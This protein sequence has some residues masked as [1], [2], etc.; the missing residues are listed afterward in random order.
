M[1]IRFLRRFRVIRTSRKI[2]SASLLVNRSSKNSTR[3]PVASRSHPPKD[4][5]GAGQVRVVW[6]DLVE[7]ALHRA[8]R[9]R[10]GVL[11]PVDRARR[12]W[13]RLAQA[14]DVIA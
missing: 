8:V 13:H 10:V 3:T 14:V 11:R 12:T 4:R 7:P 2:C 6:V 1:S 5:A 9:D